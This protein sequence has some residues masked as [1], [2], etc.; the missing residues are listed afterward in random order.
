MELKR[1]K[2]T[3]RG[4]EAYRGKGMVRGDGE[5]ERGCGREIKERRESEK[6]RTHG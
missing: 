2:G 5:M 1:Q 6:G 3:E 4:R